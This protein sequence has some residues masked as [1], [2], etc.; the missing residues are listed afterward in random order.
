MKDFSRA[1]YAHIFSSYYVFIV[2]SQQSKGEGEELPNLLGEEEV[3]HPPPR[4]FENS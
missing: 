3:A 2:T 1:D 4:L